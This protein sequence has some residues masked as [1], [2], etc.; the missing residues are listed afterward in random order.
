MIA[1]L[2]RADFNPTEINTDLHKRVADAIQDGFI[3]GF[4]MC[5][6]SRDRDQ[7]LSIWMQ[8]DEVVVREIMTSAS[9]ATRSPNKADPRRVGHL[10][11]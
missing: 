1:L 8:D 7:D 6:N 3:R 10:Q 4:D 2:K 5:V 9:R 11:S